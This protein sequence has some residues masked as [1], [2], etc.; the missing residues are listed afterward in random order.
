[1][2]IVGHGIDLVE[3]ADVL[4]LI[5]QVGY[6]SVLLDWCTV[7]EQLSMPEAS[8]RRAAHLAGLIAAKEAISKALGSG[9]VGDMLWT[10]IEVLRAA[11]GRPY[12]VLHGASAVKADQNGVS[13]VSVSITHTS[14]IVAASAIA[15]GD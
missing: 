11:S 14:A 7:D 4:A 1:M 3:I 13:S 9:L 12:V 2:R 8:G 6:E 10:Q 5:E 15:M